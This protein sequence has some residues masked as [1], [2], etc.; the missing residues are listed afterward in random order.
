MKLP[1]PQQA[2]Y[3]EKIQNYCL[4]FN[5]GRGKNKA[6][7]FRKKLGITLDNV[8][9]L[10][11]ALQKAIMTEQVI[12]H[13]QNDFGKYYDLKFFLKTDQGE[14]WVLSAWIVRTGENFPRLVSC[15]PLRQ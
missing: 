14:S 10:I 6:Y 5:H 7:L 13:K 9:I 15:Y 11:E 2:D 8:E 3:L 4:N 1:N 12:L